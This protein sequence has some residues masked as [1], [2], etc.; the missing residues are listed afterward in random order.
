[1]VSAD[2][3]VSAVNQH[4]AGGMQ[5][6]VGSGTSLLA[7][8]GL[9]QLCCGSPA[10]LAMCHLNQWPSTQPELFGARLLSGTSAVSAD[11]GALM[12]S[13]LVIGAQEACRG[14]CELHGQTPSDR[15]GR[16]VAKWLIC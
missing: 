10:P 5:A 4:C 12:Q 16:A 15:K 3:C 7:G 1:M 14:L 6:V 13:E 8:G 2:I 11:A 9:R